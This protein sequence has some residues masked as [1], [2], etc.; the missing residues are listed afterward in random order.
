MVGSV[1]HEA[2][3]CDA[4]G[5]KPPGTQWES[6]CANVAI[7]YGGNQAPFNDVDQCQNQ[8]R[9]GSAVTAYVLMQCAHNW[10]QVMMNIVCTDKALHHKPEYSFTISLSTADSCK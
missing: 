8:V 7:N 9:L 10:R 6:L 5:E 4:Q 1:A 2:E 3:L